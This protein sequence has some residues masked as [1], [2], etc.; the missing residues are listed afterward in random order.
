MTMLNTL[1]SLLSHRPG[2]AY[3][4]GD[5]LYL[6]PTV[7]SPAANTM[8]SCR[9]P[10]FE[11]GIIAPLPAS[12]TSQHTATA[13]ESGFEPLPAG[14]DDPTAE[15]LAALVDDFYA[16]RTESLGSMGENDGGVV[17][18][19]NGDPLA[20]TNVVLETVRL[21]AERRNG[22]AFRLNTLGLCDTNDIDLLLSSGVVARGDVDQRRE[23]RIATVSVFL[24]AAN[25]NKYAEL[26]QPNDGRG[27]SNAC[28]FVARLAEAGVDVECTAVARPDIN[29]GEVKA[30]AMSLGA[31]S[32]RTRSWMG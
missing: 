1:R 28:S 29:V 11:S 32:F 2:I 31:T 30:L 21:V 17:F 4:L 12:R 7:R 18:Q 16:A 26:L 3:V 23:T 24:P 6:S 19:G 9:G 25:P 27:F 20:A 13:S 10:S 5:T 15:E 22:I 8:R 14:A